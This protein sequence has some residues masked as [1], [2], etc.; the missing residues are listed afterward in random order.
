VAGGASAASASAIEAELQALA[1]AGFDVPS[2]LK[3]GR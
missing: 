1:F 2:P 3:G